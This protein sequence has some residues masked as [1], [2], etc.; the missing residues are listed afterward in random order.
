MKAYRPEEILEYAK[1]KVSVQRNQPLLLPAIGVLI[2]AG[3][4]ILIKMMKDKADMLQ[5]TLVAD[6]GFLAGVAFAILF[7][8]FAAIG[9]FGIAQALQSGKGIEHQALKRLI[10]LEK[11]Q[12]GQPERP[13]DGSTRA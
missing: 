7:M 4:V 11:K 10:E 13:G 2:V 8:I 1:R 9:G 6:E 3:L 5:S 12:I